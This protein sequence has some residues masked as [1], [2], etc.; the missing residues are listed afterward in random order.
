SCNASRST[1]PTL[2]L[3][4][5][6][7]GQL[8][9]AATL[10]ALFCVFG[11]RAQDGGVAPVPQSDLDPNAL[12]PFIG[13]V[14]VGEEHAF[15]GD[16]YRYLFAIHDGQWTTAEWA[17]DSD[18]FTLPPPEDTHVTFD[19]RTIG[20]LTIGGPH[21]VDPVSSPQMAAIRARAER[22]G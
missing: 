21:M 4:R 1:M 12:T 7:C 16:S 8:T 11:A 3:P 20:D 15:V 13:V 5:G 6:W 9:A 18:D 17:R 22:L 2:T 19:G 14:E 10:T